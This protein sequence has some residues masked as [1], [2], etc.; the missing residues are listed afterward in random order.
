MRKFLP[1]SARLLPVLTMLGCATALVG[2]TPEVAQTLVQLGI[3]LS[4]IRTYATLQDAL[5]TTAARGLR[6]N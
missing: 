4:G 1:R 5:Q 3:D 2:T 6:R